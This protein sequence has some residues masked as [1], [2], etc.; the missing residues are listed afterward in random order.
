MTSDPTAVLADAN[1]AFVDEDY[2]RA[3][4]LYTTLIEAEP[5]NPEFLLKRAAAHAKLGSHSAALTDA[6]AAIMLADGKVDVVGK[7]HLRRGMALWELGKKTEARDAF[8]EAQ[9]CAGGAGQEDAVLKR[10]LEK[11]EKELPK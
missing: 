1:S 3:L 2:S 11:S 10:W 9:R 6:Q 7:A 8:V 5:S 4:S